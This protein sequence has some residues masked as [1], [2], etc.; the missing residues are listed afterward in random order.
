ML[1]FDLRSYHV[2]YFSVALLLPSPCDIAASFWSKIQLPNPNPNPNPNPGYDT[3]RS[4]NPNP[5]PNLNPNPKLGDSTV[6]SDS[7]LVVV[8]ERQGKNHV[9]LN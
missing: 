3:A 2:L 5:N 6:H 1:T 4:P 7:V 8:S 9:S